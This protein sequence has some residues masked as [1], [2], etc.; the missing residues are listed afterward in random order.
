MNELDQV[1]QVIGRLE[2]ATS[3]LEKQVYSVK[4]YAEKLEPR[5]CSLERWRSWLPTLVVLALPWGFLFAGDLLPL[6]LEQ[7]LIPLALGVLLTLRRRG[8]RGGA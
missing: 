7:L 5:V 2:Q 4:E 3:E 8:R 1:S 6:G